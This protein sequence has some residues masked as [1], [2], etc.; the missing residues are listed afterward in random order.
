[1]KN[2]IRT[3]LWTVTLSDDLRVVDI[4]TT[5]SGQPGGEEHRKKVIARVNADVQA[6]IAPGDIATWGHEY[7]ERVG[8]DGAHFWMSYLS[9]TWNALYDG[10]DE[11]K[12][13]SMIPRLEDL[14]QA[15]KD[16][17]AETAHR[18]RTHGY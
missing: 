18:V 1:M 2:V 7:K 13:R 6:G 3:G 8:V 15:M 14:V 11:A 10:M 12:R 9:L 4:T 17:G 16:A 5:D